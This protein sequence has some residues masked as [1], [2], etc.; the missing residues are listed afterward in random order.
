MFFWLQVA[1]KK[2]KKKTIL[3]PGD[4]NPSS[5]DNQNH[6]DQAVSEMSYDDWL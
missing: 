4:K 2:K 3:Q 5:A 1:K 6:L